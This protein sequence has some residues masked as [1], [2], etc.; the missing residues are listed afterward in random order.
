[1]PTHQDVIEQAL[2]SAMQ[3]ADLELAAGEIGGHLAVLHDAEGAPVEIDEVLT[4]S[5]AGFMTSNSGVVLRLS[6]G[7]EFTVE[8]KAYRAPR[9]GWNH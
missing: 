7:S 3:E 1:M 9:G 2:L 6:D 5:S 8:I 4:L